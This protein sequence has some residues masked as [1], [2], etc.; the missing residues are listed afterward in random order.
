MVSVSFLFIY[1]FH[2]IL[3]ILFYLEY[4]NEYST[5]E[6]LTLNFEES[7]LFCIIEGGEFS[8]PQ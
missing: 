8:S 2:I 3:F 5:D 1:Y 6:Y 7:S 4:P